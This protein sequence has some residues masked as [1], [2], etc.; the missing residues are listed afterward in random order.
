MK[1]QATLTI[2]GGSGFESV[3]LVSG[4]KELRRAPAIFW[5]DPISGALAPADVVFEAQ[6]ISQQWLWTGNVA[7]TPPPVILS[8]TIFVNNSPSG[9][10]IGTVYALSQP[11]QIVVLYYQYLTPLVNPTDTSPFITNY[12]NMVISKARAIALAQINDPQWEKAEQEYEK[13]LGEAIRADAH[14]EVAGHNLHMGQG[15]RVW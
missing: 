8:N 9:A 1:A 15:A 14:A 7:G 6:Q 3:V 2:P 13:K 12:P 4:F 10:I 5:I 11:V